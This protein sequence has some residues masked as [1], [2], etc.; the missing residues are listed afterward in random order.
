[1]TGTGANLLPDFLEPPEEVG[2]RRLRLPLAVHEADSVRQLAVTEYQS[3]L[4][5]PSSDEVG[6]VEGSW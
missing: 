5:L 2:D 6:A 1:M 4:S 3:Q